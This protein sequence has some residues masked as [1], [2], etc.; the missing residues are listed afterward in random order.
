MFKKITAVLAAVLLG[1]GISVVSVAAPASAHTPNYGAACN[2]LWV[3]P[4]Q[5]ETRSGNAT[6]NKITVVIDGETVLDQAFGNQLAKQ[7]FPLDGT[8]S[9]TWSIVID[10]VGG[11]GPDTQYDW[12]KSGVTA[13]CAYPDRD[14]D[15]VCGT[16]TAI[17]DAALANGNHINMEVLINGV[18][19]TLNAYVDQNVP[20]GWSGPGWNQAGLRIT[21]INGAQTAVP[22]TQ[23]QILSGKFTFNYGD[24]IGGATTYSVVWVQMETIHFNDTKVVSG[25]L[26]CG[27]QDITVQTA[28][29]A[30]VA[31]CDADGKLVVPAQAGIIWSGGD[32]G[33]G[34]GTYDLV[35]KP[36]AGYTLSGQT[37]WTIV[38]PP[39]KSGVE[40]APPCIP[41]TS[42]SYTYDPATNSGVIHVENVDGS[43]GKLC[44][45]F[46]VTATSWK[47]IEGDKVWSQVRDVVQQLPKI[48]A[49]GDYP[50]VAPVD[51]GQGDIYASFTESPNP[52]QYLHGP[53][54][55][56]AEHFLHEM[57]FSGP[58]PTF[59]QDSP[60]CNIV[61]PV[62]PTATVIDECGEF[63]SVQVPAESVAFTYTVVGGPAEG[64]VTVTAH[65]KEGYVVQE[66]AKTVFEFDLGTHTPCKLIPGDPSSTD[67]KCVGGQL[68]S[69]S[70]TVAPNPGKIV[71]VITG[72]SIQA[73]GI[74]VP[75]NNP[76]TSLPAGSYTVTAKGINGNTVGPDNTWKYDI[77]IGGPEN[78][79][80]PTHALLKPTA[81]Q[82]NGS[83]TA[84]PTYTLS[85]TTSVNG[86]VQ[87]WIG[88]PQV[89]TTPGTHKAS[90]G[91]TVVVQAKLADPVADGFEKDAQTAYT[92]KFP[93]K[94]ACGDL[95]TLALTGGSTSGSV[96]W[97]A[98]TL[99]LLGAA[100]I[101]FQRRLVTAKK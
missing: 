42:V 71:F 98:G 94:P 56:W 59:T 99:L 86:G 10:A 82:N 47:F 81:S 25:Y 50:Y 8:T 79:D 72:G 27:F 48:D 87:W 38:V 37:E 75:D 18:K 12:T 40:C 51:C 4:T 68:T 26:D 90:W 76:V 84:D 60:G 17:L 69:G 70:I 77:V 39:M 11:S 58:N 73:P 74:T 93:A 101:Y 78:C 3:N 88:D 91:S 1:V 5:Y 16:A 66:G 35:A 55:P 54:N 89:Q 24:F 100:G 97:I 49:P 13:P 36:A 61:V 21:D 52:P 15:L 64:K 63:G 53:S 29:T 32:N 6:P 96:L 44:D 41:N 67:Q 83:C 80:L 31:T 34:P 95:L 30:T 19:K 57:G 20:G 43:T 7:T 45:P 9:H 23:Q 62:T 14:L 22:L 2:S 46:W 92:F 65:V 28:P 85:N 33:A